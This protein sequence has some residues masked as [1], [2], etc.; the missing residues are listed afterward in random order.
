MSNSE[1]A[2]VSRMEIGGKIVPV[3]MILDDS[4]TE[5]DREA[6]A[7]LKKKIEAPHG[8]VVCGTS[9][10]KVAGV[11]F[12]HPDFERWKE[13]VHQSPPWAYRDDPLLKG[14]NEETWKYLRNLD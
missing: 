13:R 8:I 14:M 12:E 4:A 3:R 5:A 6:W 1:F 7:E 9:P 11:L 2:I 10:A